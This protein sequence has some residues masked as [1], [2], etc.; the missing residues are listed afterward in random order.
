MRRLKLA[1]LVLVALWCV[2]WFIHAWHYV[3]DDAYIHLEF[4]CSVSHGQGFAFNGRVV[5]GDTAPLWVLLL[6]AVHAFLVN[7]IIAAK[8]LAV[9]GAAIGF[10]GI[11]ALAH[12]L[13]GALPGTD[14]E[15]FPAAMVA[16]V[17]VSPFTCYWIFSGM[18]ALAAAG[19]ACWAVLFA[20]R[21]QP[22]KSSF[23][24]GCLLGGIGPLIRPEMA[25]LTLLLVVPL[26]GQWRRLEAPHRWK[27]FGLG[28]LL[29]SGPLLVWSLYSL[30]AF[31]HLLPNTN[32]AKRAGPDD[33]VMKHLLSVYGVGFPLVL[34]GA[35]GALAYMV[36]RG[37]KVCRSLSNAARSTWSGILQPQGMPTA[38]WILI[39]WALVVTLF[40]IANHTYVQTRYILPI[41]PG[42]L[43]VVVVAAFALS[44]SLGRTVYAAALLEMLVVSML[45]A[46][47][48]VRNKAFNCEVYADL[49]K[50]IRQ[51][52]PPGSPVG[53]Y[54]IGEIAFLSQYPIIDTG[55][56]TQ[57]EALQ[58]INDSP[59]VQARWA[60]TMGARYFIGIKPQAHSELVYRRPTRFVG[61]T[62]HPSRYD[63][64]ELVELWTLR[65]GD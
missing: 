17:A 38:G 4:A 52:L 16:L 46:R 19:L 27:T 62:I 56:I 63:R 13:A 14:R 12:R 29:F 36:A 65:P 59:I 30:H 6:V 50:Y 32:A 3:E 35:S 15:V 40:Y 54:S 31:G 2:C 9:L 5:A 21:E 45:I 44:R 10:S 37:S 53:T 57:P 7:W 18:E 42:L 25:F 34:G 64:T 60:Q 61:W 49:A 1:L 47:P 51:H 58:Y 28:L 11:Y 55:G 41:A 48:F 22:R 33:S 43:V 26:F 8:A 39:L 20:T 23:L 24:I